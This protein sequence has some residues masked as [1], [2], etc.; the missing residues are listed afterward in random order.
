MKRTS[1]I[2]S[3]IVAFLLALH[4]PTFASGNEYS[5]VEHCSDNKNKNVFDL[6]KPATTVGV[7]RVSQEG[8]GNR[9]TELHG[10]SV[11]ELNVKT[12]QHLYGPK[13]K[14]ATI[15]AYIARKDDE[16]YGSVHDSFEARYESQ[17]NPDFIITSVNRGENYGFYTDNRK[18]S[19]CEPIP[20]LLENEEYLVV[21]E[22]NR[23]ISIEPFI[24]EKSYWPRFINSLVE[25]NFFL[26][27]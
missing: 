26:R 14:E 6:M 20:V 8:F 17:S 12:T 9:I 11:I 1:F 2:A 13:N 27:R 23:V 19:H 24:S 22:N 18:R 16:N 21:W 7:I 10:S 15:V 4:S 3:I 5:L 25:N